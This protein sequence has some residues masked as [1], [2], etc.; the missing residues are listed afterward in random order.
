MTQMGGGSSFSPFAYKST[1][2]FVAKGEKTTH[3]R[4]QKNSFQPALDA[5]ILGVSFLELGAPLRMLPFAESMRFRNLSQVEPFMLARLFVRV[6]LFASAALISCSSE[7]PRPRRLFRNRGKQ[8]K[9][10]REGLKRQRPSLRA[11]DKLTTCL[12]HRST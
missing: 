10:V 7:Y 11:I 2:R 9:K 6:F 1:N 4:L 3:W 5:K 12:G 8:Y